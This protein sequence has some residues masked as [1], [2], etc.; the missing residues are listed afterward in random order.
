MHSQDDNQW[1]LVPLHDG[2]AFATG[3]LH[4][5]QRLVWQASSPSTKSSASLER[6]HRPH[7]R[8]SNPSEFP[9]DQP[10]KTFVLAFE[11]HVGQI[12]TRFTSAFSVCWF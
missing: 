6:V 10:S 8:A 11:Q 3:H 1:H 9:L 7:Q 5:L 2:H 12:P 4:R